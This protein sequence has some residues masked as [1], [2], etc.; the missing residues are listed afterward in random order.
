MPHTVQSSNSSRANSSRSTNAVSPLPTSRFGHAQRFESGLDVRCLDAE[1]Y[2]VLDVV[3]ASALAS[4]RRCRRL[5]LTRSGTGRCRI[6]RAP[7]TNTCSTWTTSSTLPTSDMVPWRPRQPGDL[8][9][10]VQF[11][12]NICEHP[13]AL[14]VTCMGDPGERKWCPSCTAE[15]IELPLFRTYV[16]R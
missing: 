5:R 3:G 6:C 13:N 9:K 15:W 4:T 14:P 16:G 12:Y 8:L 10:F 7:W 1:H 2:V 11:R